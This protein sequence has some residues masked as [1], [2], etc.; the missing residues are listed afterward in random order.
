MPTTA[1][2][3]PSDCVDMDCDARRKV[4]VKDVDGT[5]LG[6]SN[7]TL[8]SKSEYHWDGERMWGLGEIHF[9]YE[10]LVK[11]F[12][13]RF[14][15]STCSSFVLAFYGTFLPV[16]SDYTTKDDLDGAGH[17]FVSKFFKRFIVILI[18]CSWTLQPQNVLKLLLFFYQF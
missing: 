11:Y 17:S 18:F 14:S 8:V 12:F 16:K 10:E 7:T 4:Y 15:A 9:L 2:I 5:F 3:N 1:W 6:L 13:S